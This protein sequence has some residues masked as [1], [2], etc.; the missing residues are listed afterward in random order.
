MQPRHEARTLETALVR[1][2][3]E[4]PGEEPRRAQRAQR[5]R[6]GRRG[7]N[8]WF[9]PS[10]VPSVVMISE[11]G[12]IAMCPLVAIEAARCG[13]VPVSRI[14][15]PNGF[16]K[17]STLATSQKVDVPP[18]PRSALLRELLRYFNQIT[19]CRG[20]MP[21][22]PEPVLGRRHQGGHAM[23]VLVDV[24]GFTEI[25]LSIAGIEMIAYE[26]CANFIEVNER[27]VVYV[28][29][30]LRACRRGACPSRS[31]VSSVASAQKDPAERQFR[32]FAFLR[33]R[34]A[35]AHGG[36]KIEST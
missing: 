2:C 26:Q 4:T 28:S 31:S 8:F 9:P 15:V 32:W 18:D 14:V 25:R 13:L 36:Q 16:S 27:R 17:S 11:S 22:S 19:A 1:G 3:I 6:G 24:S 30:A 29:A 35:R 23:K 12:S 21:R 34:A 10:S 7:Q 33:L 5:A 20:A